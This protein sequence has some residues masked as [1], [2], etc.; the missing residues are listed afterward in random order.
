MDIRSVH[1][2][3]AAHEV[4]IHEQLAQRWP[5][6]LSKAVSD[7]GIGL[8]CSVLFCTGL[9]PGLVPLVSL[10]NLQKSHLMPFLG[11]QRM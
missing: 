1:E 11:A 7:S 3:C 4:K 8:G 5:L 2:R 6:P 10:N 9:V